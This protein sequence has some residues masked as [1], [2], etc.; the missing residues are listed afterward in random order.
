MESLPD[1]VRAKLKDVVGLTY[2]PEAEFC[3]HLVHAIERH[4]KEEKKQKDQ[5]KDVLRKVAQ[6]QLTELNNGLKNKKKLQA[7]L[8]EEEKPKVSETSA[9][10]VQAT[11]APVLA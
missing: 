5:E 1:K 8:L 9:V 7:P 6:L 10:P 3:E 4:R 11:Q 2:K